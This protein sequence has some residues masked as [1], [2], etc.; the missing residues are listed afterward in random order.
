MPYK[1]IMIVA[2]VLLHLLTFSLIK[3]TLQN[4]PPVPA[5]PTREIDAKNARKQ[6][7]R[8]RLYHLD[9]DKDKAGSSRRRRISSTFPNVQDAEKYTLQDLLQ[10]R[11][12]RPNPSQRLDFMELFANHPKIRNLEPYL[13]DPM[14]VKIGDLSEK[15]IST[16]GDWERDRADYSIS[17]KLHTSIKAY[18]LKAGVPLEDVQAIQGYVH[19]YHRALRTAKI[20]LNESQEA[21]EKRKQSS[22][23]G[24]LKW[25]EKREREGRPL[26]LHQ[27]L[28]NVDSSTS[29][30]SVVQVELNCRRFRNLY[31]SE[32]SYNNAVKDYLKENNYSLQ[33]AKA[34]TARR[35]ILL[36][37]ERNKKTVQ[38]W[39]EKQK[40][41]L[42]R[43]VPEQSIS[44]TP[45]GISVP[46]LQIGHQSD[47]V[48]TDSSL[49]RD[50]HHA[51]RFHLD[52]PYSFQLCSTP[53]STTIH[54]R[55]YDPFIEPDWWHMRHF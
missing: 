6:E 26:P 46:Q 8:P 39:R 1:D 2:K 52:N 5:S 33:D 36:R 51:S 32:S 18:L 30:P 48:N 42:R 23:Q 40:G 22:I 21:Q 55:T 34:A 29:R 27:F 35:V 17:R 53:N 11:P 50:N 25:R 13:R 19:R 12:L 24:T 43:A 37:Q 3:S 41:K 31:S 9:N 44:D 20:R 10:L 54:H 38:K 16:L 14:K 28:G 7:P 49:V 15:I 47:S 4:P 45:I